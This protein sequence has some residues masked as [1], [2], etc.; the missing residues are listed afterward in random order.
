MRTALLRLAGVFHVLL[1]PAFRAPRGP[2]RGQVISTPQTKP[3]PLS[4]PGSDQVSAYNK[5]RIA[6]KEDPGTPMR[7]GNHHGFIDAASNR[8][9]YLPVL[10][11]FVANRLPINLAGLPRHFIELP[12]QS[13]ILIRKVRSGK[14]FPF[15]GFGRRP[16]GLAKKTGVQNPIIRRPGKISNA[17]KE[18]VNESEVVRL[19]TQTKIVNKDRNP[20]T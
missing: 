18:K 2:M 6:G 15:D 11:W 13:V 17:L 7:N 16:I 20:R 9:R 5:N 12:V 19:R 4:M 1:R 3:M 14:G 10:K 8:Y